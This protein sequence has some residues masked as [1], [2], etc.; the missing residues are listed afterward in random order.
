MFYL[1]DLPTDETLKELVKRFPDLDVS[2]LRACALLLRTGSDLLTE[3]ERFLGKIGLSQ[4]KFLTL[5]VMNRAPDEEISPS[6]VAEKLGVTRSTMTGLLDGL[7]KSKLIERL[8]HSNDRR[9]LAVRLTKQGRQTLRKIL[10]GYYR[11]INTVMA[12]LNEAERSD[13]MR[14]LQKVNQGLARLKET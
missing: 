3:F 12:D 4:G 7:E 5:I 11:M 10:P 13:L 14:H 2:A 8:P 9:K 1:K 6:T